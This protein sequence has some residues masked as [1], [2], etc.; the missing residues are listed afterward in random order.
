MTFADTCLRLNDDSIP[1]R[2]YRLLHAAQHVKHCVNKQ[3]HV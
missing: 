3:S 2:T 1:V